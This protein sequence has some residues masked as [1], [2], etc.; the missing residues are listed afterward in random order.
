M[1]V[2][3]EVEMEM[4]LSVFGRVVSSVVGEGGYWF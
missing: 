2:E 3:V 1:E 4:E